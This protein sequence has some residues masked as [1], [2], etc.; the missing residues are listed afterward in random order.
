[1]QYPAK[2]LVHRVALALSLSCAVNLTVLYFDWTSSFVL[3]L[4]LHC[5]LGIRL[6]APCFVTEFYVDSSASDINYSC[7]IC[8][9]LFTE[10][11]DP[12][13]WVQGGPQLNFPYCGLA[14]LV[15]WASRAAHTKP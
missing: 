15:G 14:W 6:L 10:S 9:T 13:S 3:P 8:I 12:L 1:M 11:H 4:Q 5:L 7:P 2:P